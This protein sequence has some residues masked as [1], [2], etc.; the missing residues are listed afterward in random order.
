MI[1][2]GLTVAAPGAAQEAKK[3]EPVVVTATKI[4]TRQEELG[5][6]VTVITEE[7]LRTLNQNQLADVL[8]QVPGV[9]IQRFGGPG[10]LAD[11]RIRGASPTQ[12][13][14]LV[15]G[16]RVKNDSS[17]R[18]GLSGLALDAIGRVAVVRVPES[19][20]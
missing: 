2:V 18:W 19:G 16:M 3:L 12:V 1:L 14:V 11:I 15:D 5:A 4:E 7:D 8:R 17:G 13:Q 9:E 10:K 6:A 20:L